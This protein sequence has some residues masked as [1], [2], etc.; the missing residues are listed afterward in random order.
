M[1]TMLP[2]AEGWGCLEQEGGGEGG[3]G[4][5]GFGKGGGGFPGLLA[6]VVVVPLSCVPKTMALMAAMRSIGER[7]ETLRQWEEELWQK[8][9]LVWER[10]HGV[11]ADSR[12]RR[13]G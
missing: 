9:A 8:N 5:G 10:M 6:L 4:G 12:L 7:A 13:W 2:R 1:S 11:S 3:V